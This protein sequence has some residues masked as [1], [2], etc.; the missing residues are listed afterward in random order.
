MACCTH[1]VGVSC[2]LGRRELVLKE[3]VRGS[4]GRCRV[5]EGAGPLRSPGLARTHSPVSAAFLF[6]FCILCVSFVFPPPSH[7]QR[8]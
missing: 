7:S 3:G 4:E 5:G 2:G 8:F 1:G 6:V